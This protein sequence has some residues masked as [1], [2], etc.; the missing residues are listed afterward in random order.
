MG[1][2]RQRTLAPRLEVGISRSPGRR[3]ILYRTEDVSGISGTGPVAEGIE[4]HDGQAVISWFGKF[5]SLE[6]HPSVVQVVKL[7]GHGGRTVVRWIDLEDS[8]GRQ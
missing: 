6:V 4:F 7:H 1:V 2:Q 3:F 8:N 5:H